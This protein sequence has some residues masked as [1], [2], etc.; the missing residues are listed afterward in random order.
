MNIMET[1]M[2]VSK[3]KQNNFHASI[4]KTKIVDVNDQVHGLP[5]D[6][7]GFKHFK[8][9]DYF[10]PDSWS[11]TGY[12]IPVNEG[13]PMWFDLT[14]N[15]ECACIVSVQKV[16]PVIQEKT[17]IEVGLTNDPQ[18]NYLKLPEQKWL[19]GPM[20]GG[21]VVQFVA[22][23][24]G[25][26]M[27]LNEYI[28]DEQDQDSQAITFIF[29]SPKNPKTN[30]PVY[31]FGS[32]YEA[33]QHIG[34]NKY[35]NKPHNTWEFQK[36]ILR[37]HSPIDYTYNTTC[38][39]EFRK[40]TPAAKTASLNTASV[41]GVYSCN[42]SNEP[43]S[44]LTA[45]SIQ[46]SKVDPTIIDSTLNNDIT[47]IEFDKASMSQGGRINQG[48]FIDNNTADYY[49]ENP[50]ATI[51]VYMALPDQFKHIMEKGLRQYASIKDKYT[52][53]TKLGG[54]QVPLMVPKNQQD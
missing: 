30:S 32:Y 23:K 5:P 38:P 28:L 49:K 13:E 48:L 52:Y 26:G 51:I 27:A 2:H 15:G 6:L 4:R 14:G 24:A 3:I 29:Y 19:D 16:N 1:F 37:G 36:S 20:A 50:D 46:E 12:F 53:S 39:P 9:A 42:E 35:T 41:M 8:V 25:V 11:K 31:G 21:K 17:D 43:E 18:Q 10:C 54:K 7:G 34:W 40:G 22:T 33:L 47:E 44:I 45:Q